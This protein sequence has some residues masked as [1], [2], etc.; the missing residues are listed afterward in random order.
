[1]DVNAAGRVLG[2]LLGGD[3]EEKDGDPEG[4]P[5]IPEY[6]FEAR[7]GGGGGGE[8][9]RAYRG[10]SQRPLAVKILRHRL[11]DSAE[12]TR[13]WR[14][15]DV[16]G[17]V[18]LTCVP[19]LVD[20]GVC[21]GRMYIATEFVE[22]RA[23][24]AHCTEAGLDREGRVRLLVKVAEAVH[25]LH[26]HGVIHRDIKPSNVIVTPS[27]DPV[28]IDLGIAALLNG[29]PMETLTRE[30]APIGSP[31]FMAP[32]QARGERSAVST[33]SDVYGLGATAYVV[34]T[35][36]TPHDMDATLHEAVRRVAQDEPRLPRALDPGLPKALSAVLRKAVARRGEDRYASAVELAEDLQ[37]W[38]RREPVEAGERSMLERAGAF[39]AHHPIVL[40]AA[41]CVTIA[42]LTLVATYLSVLW[43][44]MMPARIVV[45]DDGQA[46]VLK[47]RSGRELNRWDGIIIR[48]KLVDCPSAFGGG[49]RVVLARSVENRPD[50]CTLTVYDASRAGRMIW[51]A[52]TVLPSGLD[53]LLDTVGPE[54][55]GSFHTTAARVADVFDEVPGPEIISVS[56]HTP[57]SWSAVQI[58]DLS[59]RMRDEIWHNGHIADVYW[60]EKA[61][62]LVCCGVN[63]EAIWADRGYPNAPALHYPNVVFAVGP[64]LQRQGGVWVCEL[65][66]P[67]KLLP[68]WYLC[69]LPP[70]SS[71]DF[72]AN[73]FDV[74]PPGHDPDAYVRFRVHRRGHREDQQIAWI[75]DRTGQVVGQYCTDACRRAPSAGVPVAALTLG[76]LPAR[77]NAEAETDADPAPAE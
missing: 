73:S 39:L 29:E 7:L 63:S 11:D 24:D 65:E 23:L 56:N 69:L 38:L 9:Y 52:R 8:V 34:L 16:L 55:R 70:R 22:G 12:A 68:E 76:P 43:Y 35:G 62:L 30:G 20:Y 51:Q 3:D 74:P 14:E 10:G 18:R 44:N 53:R 48:A 57:H 64:Q 33:R 41:V 19:R 59:G 58:H 32:E 36:K 21:D 1:M 31:A 71:A 75:L 27:G 54:Y 4:F 25:A 77:T 50:L 17:Q 6:V 13:A 49:K 66:S 67:L 37:R 28:L 61:G 42:V 72:A 2:S 47:A 26:E 5:S 40:T 46:A 60:L 45:S 15:L